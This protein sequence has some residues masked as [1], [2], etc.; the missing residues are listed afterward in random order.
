[1]ILFRLKR[2]G[3]IVMLITTGGFPRSASACCSPDWNRCVLR[4]L[5]LNMRLSAVYSY[6]AA[7]TSMQHI[8]HVAAVLTYALCSWLL[9]SDSSEVMLWYSLYCVIH[10]ICSGI[11]CIVVW[12]IVHWTLVSSCSRDVVHRSSL[13]DFVDGTNPETAFIARLFKIS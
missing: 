7:P 1:M 9:C 2:K 10:Q 4:S 12:A 8:N 6:C 5:I 13:K 3:R 11:H